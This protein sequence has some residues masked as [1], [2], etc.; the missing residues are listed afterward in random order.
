MKYFP[1]LHWWL[2][3]ITSNTSHS[4]NNYTCSN[5]YSSCLN[6]LM[7]SDE[8]W[9]WISMLTSMCSTWVLYPVAVLLNS[10]QLW[11]KLCMGISKVPPVLYSSKTVNHDCRVHRE[12]VW[13]GLN[14]SQRMWLHLKAQEGVCIMVL[15]IVP[16]LCTQHFLPSFS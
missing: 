3:C 11:Y 1:V 12:V 6:I 8:L 5:T 14:D 15:A 4:R 2:C 7:A 16:L 13:A 9:L 10:A